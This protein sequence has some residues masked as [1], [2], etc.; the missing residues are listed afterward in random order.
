MGNNIDK[1][2]THYLNDT[3]RFDVSRKS[4]LSGISVKISK[5]VSLYVYE[6]KKSL[7]F[8]SDFEFFV[9]I[10]FSESVRDFKISPLVHPTCCLGAI[11]SE[12]ESVFMT[13]CKQ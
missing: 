2:S 1:S 5:S 10:G 6:L 3:I 12:S 4:S 7:V 8:S 13:G 11:S 9:F